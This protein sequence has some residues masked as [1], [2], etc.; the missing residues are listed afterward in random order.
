MEL[1]CFNS[2][3]INLPLPR[4]QEQTLDAPESARTSPMSLLRV[5]LV[6][7]AALLGLVAVS[8]APSSRMAKLQHQQQQHR[9][10]SSATTLGSP[11]TSMPPISVSTTT[12]EYLAALSLPY[13]EHLITTDDGYILTAFR[14]PANSSKGRKDGACGLSFHRRSSR[15]VSSRLVSSRLVSS[16]LDRP[17]PP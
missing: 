9:H 7:M 1:C 8:A 17:L 2:A 4:L 13:E 14:I 16:H 12:K 15:L 11:T 5:T 10:A 3:S 6:A